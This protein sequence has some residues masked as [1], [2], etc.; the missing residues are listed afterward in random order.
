MSIK[1]SELTT[2]KAVKILE[3]LFNG[4]TYATSEWDHAPMLRMMAR[5]PKAF[6]IIN[7]TKLLAPLNKGENVNVNYFDDQCIKV[8][9]TP[10]GIEV[11]TYNANHGEGHAEKLL[12]DFK[13]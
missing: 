8:L 11:P 2:E 3:V 4:T 13:F 7:A 10:T 12:A 6:N 5:M 1:I 9:F